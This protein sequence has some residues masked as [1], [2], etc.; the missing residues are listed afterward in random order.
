MVN[1]ESHKGW[2]AK[3]VL[4]EPIPSSDNV[5]PHPDSL[6][7][8]EKKEYLQ[9]FS[10]TLQPSKVYGEKSDSSRLYDPM[11]PSVQPKDNPAKVS[12]KEEVNFSP[13]VKDEEMVFHEKVIHLKDHQSHCR[14][15]EP[16]PKRE[17]FFREFI[18]DE[19]TEENKPIL[20]SKK[21]EGKKL[22]YLNESIRRLPPDRWR[23]PSKNQAER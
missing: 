7:I 14:I 16:L 9:N 10:S 5:L 3:L 15:K 12:S 6:V 8:K 2:P 20:A 19:P 11:Q 17:F 22:K 18:T 13:E 1:S 4:G 23:S 21:K